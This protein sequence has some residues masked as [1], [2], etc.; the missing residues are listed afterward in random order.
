MRELNTARILVVDDQESNVRLLE[1]LLRRSG[2]S[3]HRSLTDPLQV[4]PVYREYRPD[5]IL[6]DLHMP[7]LN[8]YGVLEQLRAVVPGAEYLP[9]LVLTADVTREARE[10]ALTLG[11]K[12]FLQKPFD[13]TEVMLRI[14]N[15]LETRFLHQQLLAQNEALDQKVIERTAELDVARKETLD[16]LWLVS[17]FRDDVT[18]K[19]AR[20]VGELSALVVRELGLS[21][22]LVE[23]YRWAAP[24]HDLGKIAVPDA[25]LLKPG[26]LTAEEFDVMKVHTR[27]GGDLLAGSHW[28][29]L[30]LAEVI[31]RTHHER[32]DGAGYMGLEGEAIP[33]CGR[34]VSVTDVFD[35]LTHERPYKKAW[36]L[37]ETLAELRALAGKAFDP[38][39]VETFLGMIESGRIPLDDVAPAV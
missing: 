39:V 37:D 19:H 26:R 10:R 16:R 36:P 25:I 20:R 35:A 24:L 22:E 8:G 29:V 7:N 13:A 15:L 30:Q 32:W 4:L 17:D 28:P 2:Y 5:L 18:G 6:L 11:A 34:V 3:N 38:Q 23:V 21:N 1:A 14:R 12:D 33:L 9:V 27:I 31:A